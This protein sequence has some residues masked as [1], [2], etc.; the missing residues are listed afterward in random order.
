MLRFYSMILL[1]FSC[2]LC[3]ADSEGFVDETASFI[4]SMPETS[5]YEKEMADLHQRALKS[6]R[7]YLSK[8]KQAQIDAKNYTKA[9]ELEKS[10]NKL[11]AELED[12]EIDNTPAATETF[13]DGREWNS[14]ET[15]AVY[16]VRDGKLYRDGTEA[17]DVQ[18][19][20][21]CILRVAAR[22]E[23]WVWC[24]SNE[25]M[26][27]DA[28]FL[29]DGR[30]YMPTILK[31]SDKTSPNSNSDVSGNADIDRL[32]QSRYQS[33]MRKNM[34]P[35]QRKYVKALS[36]KMDA[37]AK[38]GDLSQA[39]EIQKYISTLSHVEIASVK[40]TETP[41]RPIGKFRETIQGGWTYV[42]T[43][44]GWSNYLPSGKK[45][46][47]A[48]IIRV[49]PDKHVWVYQESDAIECIFWYGERLLRLVVHPNKSSGFDGSRIM[50]RAE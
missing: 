45:V 8:Q 43:S 26:R 27:V 13:M 3:Q 6:V 17:G 42:F 24:S 50:V 30:S 20:S 12:T 5:V 4:E 10:I 1:L 22:R 7:S 33:Y 47:D 11:A 19:I 2:M 16:T 23:L 35:I 32:V 31:T 49:S 38:E 34:A 28:A 40:S 44:K 29:E 37:C 21:P 25:A 36:A 9:A 14:K 18:V 39:A 41:K 46:S 48:K 15:G